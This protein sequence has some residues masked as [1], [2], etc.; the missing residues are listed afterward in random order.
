MSIHFVDQRHKKNFEHLKNTY[1]VNMADKDRVL[2][3]YVLAGDEECC[4]HIDDII[5]D[6]G[7][8]VIKGESALHHKWL[9]HSNKSM[10]R[11]AMHLYKWDTPT[12]YGLTESQDIQDELHGYTLYHLFYYLDERKRDVA[13]EAIRMFVYGY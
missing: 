12:A 5:E 13:F 2:L 10:I 1:R 3:V 11:L 7:G 6:D 8:A 4:E 9:T